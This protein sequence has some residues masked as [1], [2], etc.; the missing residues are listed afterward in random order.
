[1][2]PQDQKPNAFI[3]KSDIKTWPMMFEVDKDFLQEPTD[4]SIPKVVDEKDPFA[5]LK[6]SG[7]AS[8]TDREIFDMWKVMNYGTTKAYP[9]KKQNRRRFRH[10][11][12]NIRDKPQTQDEARF[13]LQIYADRSDD[14]L[15]KLPCYSGQRPNTLIFKSDIKNWPMF[16]EWNTLLI[17][18]T[19]SVPKGTN[20]KSYFN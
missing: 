15:E 11:Q 19:D 13:N 7:V 18:P 8:L 2:F 1:D 4:D 10:F 12:K 17:E 14:E 6:S 9:S 16:A 3:F 5:K 20:P